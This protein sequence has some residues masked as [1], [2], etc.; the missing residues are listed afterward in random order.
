MAGLAKP[1]VDLAELPVDLVEPPV[2]SVEARI[3]ELRHE[4]LG[5]FEEHYRRH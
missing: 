3:T 4:M 2:D 1:P 5:R